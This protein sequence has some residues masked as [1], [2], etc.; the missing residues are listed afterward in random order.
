MARSAT[1]IR[2]ATAVALAAAV[3]ASAGCSAGK[4]DPS[5]GPTSPRRPGTGCATEAPCAGPWTRR[6]AP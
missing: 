2:S 4:D 1:L 3:A 6:P 5:Q